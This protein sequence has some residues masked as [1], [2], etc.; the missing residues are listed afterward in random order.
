MMITTLTVKKLL[1]YVEY[2]YFYIKINK[3]IF[4]QLL[5]FVTI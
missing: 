4:D 3:I 2:I 5:I 1:F